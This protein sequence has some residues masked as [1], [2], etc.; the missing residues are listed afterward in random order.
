[1]R[2]YAHD[3]GL[4]SGPRMLNTVRTPSAW[5]AQGCSLGCMGLQPGV[6]SVAAWGACGCSLGC[7]AWQPGVH[8]AAA[9]VT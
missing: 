2:K 1:M 7:K 9:W 8:G 4:S 6:H 3:A 5:G